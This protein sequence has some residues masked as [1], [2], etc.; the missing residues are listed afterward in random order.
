MLSRPNQLPLPAEA[1]IKELQQSGQQA[2]LETPSSS[3]DVEC[4]KAQFTS[5]MADLLPPE[6]SACCFFL[7]RPPKGE[8]L[9]TSDTGAAAY[10]RR[11]KQQGVM[12]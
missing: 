6:S 12:K 9:T 10:S 1:V 7:V 8:N 3:C 4:V 2:Q 11:W 5:P